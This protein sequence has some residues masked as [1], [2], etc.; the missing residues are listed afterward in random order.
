MMNSI[1][2]P[3]IILG[4]VALIS[5]WVLSMVNAVTA[6][7]IE[8]LQKDIQA[9]A[10]KTVLPGYTVEG[11]K[12]VKVNGKELVYWRASKT[13]DEK[14]SEKAYAFVATGQGYSGDVQSIVGVDEKGRIIAI[15][16]VLQSETPGLGARS[17]EIA[18]KKTLIG[19]I[20]GQDSGEENT[21][22]WFQQQFSGLDL[23]RK[24]QILKKGDWNPSMKEELLQ[25]NAISAI[26][27]AT[28]TSRTVK[29]SIE[30]GIEMLKSVE[31]ITPTAEEAAK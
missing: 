22:A 4:L 23:N 12:K 3:T 2:K 15:S 8:Q 19:T 1:V 6:P 13:I 30:R 11:E 17:Q 14:T 29:E 28:I 27:G 24:I 7:R 18:S 16:I 21:V 10:L 5:A 9:Q 31:T 25:Q 20:T 26:T